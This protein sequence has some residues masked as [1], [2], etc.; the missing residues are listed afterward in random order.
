MNRFS[1]DFERDGSRISD[2]YKN[3]AQFLI[4]KICE[5]QDRK[6]L[7][8]DLLKIYNPDKEY[9]I[10]QMIYEEYL[11][12]FYPYYHD[13]KD[14]VANAKHQK[15]SEAKFMKHYKDTYRHI[16]MKRYSLDEISLFGSIDKSR[17]V[18]PKGLKKRL[19]VIDAYLAHQLV[20]VRDL[21]PNT[22]VNQWAVNNDFI[23]KST[24]VVDDLIR[25]E[26]KKLEELDTF[27][28]SQREKMRK[29][30]ETHN[31]EV[32]EEILDAIERN[33]PELFEKYDE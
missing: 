22:L 8:P 25:Q 1:D 13:L 29:Y 31:F 6:E 28:L 26:S 19:A 3:E 2:Y 9:F 20:T 16:D 17:A 18:E 5:K 33:C 15:E 10:F 21:M 27:R 23:E 24:Q 7:H 30:Y 11:D 14:K 12:C 4:D 32:N